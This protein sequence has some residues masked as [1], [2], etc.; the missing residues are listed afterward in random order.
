LACLRG[1]G[2]GAFCPQGEG[3]M[4]SRFF[5]KGASNFGK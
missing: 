4:L 2:G 3:F 5:E 1:T